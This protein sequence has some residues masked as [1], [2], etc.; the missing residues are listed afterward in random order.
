[1]LFS[2]HRV[3]LRIIH[4]N[5]VQNF[6]NV[7]FN[8]LGDGVIIVGTLTLFDIM[9]FGSPSYGKMD[10]KCKLLNQAY[11]ASACVN[12]D[13]IHKNIIINTMKMYDTVYDSWFLEN[14]VNIQVNCL[15]TI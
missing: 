1:M 8:N 12:G 15:E 6:K 5:V 3:D 14:L 2:D 10:K 9:K 13:Y 11:R 7:Y 4:N